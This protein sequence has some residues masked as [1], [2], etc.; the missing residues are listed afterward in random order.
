[1]W[2][3]LKAYMVLAFTVDDAHDMK[4]AWMGGAFLAAGSALIFVIFI[5]IFINPE[6][7]TQPGD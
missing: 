7:P 4:S 1:M 2:G 3:K 6:L 5:N